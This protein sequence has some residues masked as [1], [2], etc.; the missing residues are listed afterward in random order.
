MDGNATS[1]DSRIARR[2]FVQLS[3]AAVAL[4]AGADLLT[5]AGRAYPEETGKT[6]RMGVVGGGFGA[7][8]HWHQHPNCVVT[9]V[10]DLYPERRRRLQDRYG[11]DTVYES[12]ES[13]IAEARDIDAVAVFSGATDHARHARM[14]MERGWHVISACPAC[15]SLEE[16][17]ML[18]EVKEQT[19]MRYMQAESTWY[20]Q[21]CIFARNLFREGGFG[22]LFYTE[23]EYYHDRGSVERMQQMVENRSGLPHN[24]DGTRS[25]RWGYPP[26]LYPT[27]S[28]GFLVAVTGERVTHVSCLGWR[29][30]PDL[31]D[32]PFTSDNA[33]DNPFWCQ[34]SLMRTDQDHA[35]RMNEFRRCVAGGERAQWF[36]DQA[37][38]YMAVQGLHG[39]VLH[40]RGQG[41]ESVTVPQYWKSDMLPE[42]MRIP[43]G[44]G[45]SAV[46]LCAEFVNA[47]LE[48]REPEI[49]VY[50]SLAMNVPG[51]VA[52]QSSLEAGQQLPVPCFDPA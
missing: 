36:G 19:G 35:C 20:R 52:H 3:G 24:P 13:M 14:C 49:D 8:M 22:E 26:M 51:I 50:E 32:H 45:G 42:P 1:N 38:F 17:A 29:G 21:G 23:G 44:H 25:W 47:L 18:K 16:A 39:D 28:V 43:S 37:T 27:H 7:T 40:L 10:T 41:P 30:G 34:S 4:V 46:F 11:C 12:L 15:V 31:K 5:R 2:D 9:G 33:Y 6:V 48:D